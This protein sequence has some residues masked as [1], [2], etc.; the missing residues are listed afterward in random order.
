MLLG[1]VAP[2]RIRAFNSSALGRPLLVSPGDTNPVL[3]LG[4][5]PDSGSL[6]FNIL[7]GGVTFNIFSL[8]LSKTVRFG[9]LYI[10][11]S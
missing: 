6:A 7:F 4:L 9:V 2:S 1:D 11:Y 5:S 8:S 3:G 10:L